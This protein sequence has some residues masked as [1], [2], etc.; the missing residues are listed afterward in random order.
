[1]ANVP[2]VHHWK[3]GDDMNA[4]RMQ[5]IKSVID[6][7]RNPPTVRVM[8][9]S[10]TQAMTVNGRTTVVFDTL[11]NSYDPYGMWNVSASDRIT[12][13]VAGWYAVEGVLSMNNTAAV[14]SR[15]QLELWRNN[16][17]MLLR[18]DQEALPAVGGNIN[19]RKESFMFLNFGDYVQLKAWNTAGTR[20]LMNV[21]FAESPQIRARWFSN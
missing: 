1:M 20:N 11:Y 3:A 9:L 8:R 2:I 7:L 13:Q 6:F 16:T 4:E 5:E 15:L 18:W 10:T 14:Q 12:C 17:D 21:S 19:I